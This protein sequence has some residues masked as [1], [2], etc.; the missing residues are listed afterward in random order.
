MC[1]NRWEQR[2]YDEQREQELMFVS[3]SQASEHVPPPVPQDPR[4]EERGPEK[5]PV[6]VA[7]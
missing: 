5:V 2:L 4:E 1:W 7:D 3:D 6:V